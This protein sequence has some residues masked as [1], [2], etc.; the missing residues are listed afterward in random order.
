MAYTANDL[1]EDYRFINRIRFPDGNGVNLVNLQER[2]QDECD[3][4]GI[5]VAMRSDVLKT[6]GLFNKQ[7][8]EVL[9]LYN[10]QHPTDYLQFLIRITHQGKYAFMDVYKVGSSKNYRNTNVAAGGSTF[11]KLANAI[12][13]TNAKLQEEENFYTILSDCFENVV[14]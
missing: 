1:N 11:R 10:T 2:L 13:G 3:S 5:P 14:S 4:N 8:E 7:T 6:G 9:V 12:S